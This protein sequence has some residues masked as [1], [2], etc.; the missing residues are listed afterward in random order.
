MAVGAW[1]AN[2]VMV[3]RIWEGGILLWNISGHLVSPLRAG[4]CAV[5]SQSRMWSVRVESGS[6][7]AVALRGPPCARPSGP[8]WGGQN[9]RLRYALNRGLRRHLQVGGRPTTTPRPPGTQV[10]TGITS[11]PLVRAAHR[12]VV[13][14]YRGGLGEGMTRAVAQSA[15]LTLARRGRDVA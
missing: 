10:G 13:P 2:P 8:A 4:P 6:G 12:N 7:A 11:R 15:L 5:R 3:W 14:L 9:F 1:L